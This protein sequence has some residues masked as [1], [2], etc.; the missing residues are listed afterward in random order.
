[1]LKIRQNLY[2]NIKDFK[3]LVT[4]CKHIFNFGLNRK[5]KT[6]MMR[7]KTLVP[8]GATNAISTSKRGKPSKKWLKLSGPKMS[9]IAK[10]INGGKD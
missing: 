5:L 4:L 10:F 7:T 2:A 1:M 8:Q 9:T 3:E 6:S